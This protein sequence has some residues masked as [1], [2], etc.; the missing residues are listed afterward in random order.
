MSAASLLICPSSP[1][2]LGSEGPAGTLK[3][4][5][6]QGAPV[7]AWQGAGNLPGCLWAAGEDGTGPLLTG[8]AALPVVPGH[9]AGRGRVAGHGAV[10]PGL[11]Q[12]VASLA[13][14]VPAES[15][16]SQS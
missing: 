6:Q 4:K 12:R 13:G 1:S 3:K 5:T 8:L 15:R 9:H 14:V 7:G 16:A 2:S 11:H 10:I